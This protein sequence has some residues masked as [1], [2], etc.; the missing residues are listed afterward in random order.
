MKFAGRKINRS[1][2]SHQYIDRDTGQV[3]DEKLHGDRIV[4]ALYSSALES[5][6]WLVEVASS[7]R[8]SNALGSLSYGTLLG[9]QASGTLRFLRQFG[10]KFSECLEP[11]QLQT[12]QQIFEGQIRFWEWRPMPS[13]PAI[14]VCPADSRVTVGS[15]CE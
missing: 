13:D 9:S 5:A 2:T 6:S 3:R 14:A 15:L 11:K 10:V 8:L 1:T 12:A 7:A 4:R